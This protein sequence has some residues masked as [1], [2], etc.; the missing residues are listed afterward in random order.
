MCYFDNFLQ[1]NKNQSTVDGISVY[2]LVTV[3][4]YLLMMGDIYADADEKR[5]KQLFGVLLEI[6]ELTLLNT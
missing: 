6:R 5:K 4:F 1:K 2:C 3:W